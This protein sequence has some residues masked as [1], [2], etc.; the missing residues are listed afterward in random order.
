MKAHLSS[1][2]I[3]DNCVDRNL[4]PS[5]IVVFRQDNPSVLTCLRKPYLIRGRGI[6]V[7]V[8]NT[9][10]NAHQAQGLRH[11]VLS[12]RPINEQD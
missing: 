9:H 4:A 3:P 10:L 2:L 8:M 12:H 6:K 5:N 7:V 11:M 1:H